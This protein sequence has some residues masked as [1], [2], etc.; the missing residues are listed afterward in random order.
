MILCRT[1]PYRFLAKRK[2]ITYLSFVSSG[3]P[4]YTM[5]MHSS[6]RYGYTNYIGTR[7]KK[8]ESPTTDGHNIIRLSRFYEY[9]RTRSKGNQRNESNG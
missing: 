3:N 5:E 7:F 8:N 4:L 9:T 6:I 1:D 2:K